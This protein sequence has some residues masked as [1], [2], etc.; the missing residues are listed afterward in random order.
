VPSEYFSD[1]YDLGVIVPCSE[2]VQAKWGGGME[3]FWL[4]NPSEVPVRPHELSFTIY[5]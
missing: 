5:V 2:E 3:M 1:D 4:K